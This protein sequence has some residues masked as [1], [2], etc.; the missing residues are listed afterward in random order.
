ML[1]TKSSTVPGLTH[2]RTGR[3]G[4][5][6]VECYCSFPKRLGSPVQLAWLQC[7]LTLDSADLAIKLRLMECTRF[8]LIQFALFLVGENI[9]FTLFVRD[10]FNSS[11]LAVVH[12][13]LEA[14]FFLG[15]GATCGGGIFAATKKSHVLI[16]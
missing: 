3:F 11:K 12:G 4:Q 5:F 7:S 14:V 9:F 13:N 2:G 15:G 10:F 6:V 16:V 1:K 8:E